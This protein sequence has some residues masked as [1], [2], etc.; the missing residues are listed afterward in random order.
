[1]TDQK[2]GQA[3]PQKK[4]G[5]GA[6]PKKPA[7]IAPPPANRYDTMGAKEPDI[8]TAAVP[9]S[10]PPPEN[11]VVTLADDGDGAVVPKE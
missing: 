4:Q 6:T 3:Q 11:K 8:K 5:T 2:E 7:P 1:M 10:G 9:S